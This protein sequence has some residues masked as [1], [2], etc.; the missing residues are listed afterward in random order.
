MEHG[1]LVAINIDPIT[2][3]I[4]LVYDLTRIG[5]SPKRFGDRASVVCFASLEELLNKNFIVEEAVPDDDKIEQ[6]ENR[7]SFLN[8]NAYPLNIV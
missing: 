5:K 4:F 2:S 3:E 7:Q 1:I 6:M 8:L